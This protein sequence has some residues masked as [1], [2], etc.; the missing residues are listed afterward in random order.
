MYLGKVQ[1]LEAGKCLM[2]STKSKKVTVARVEGVMEIRSKGPA[3]FL[4]PI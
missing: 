2:C 1:N 4:G 3:E